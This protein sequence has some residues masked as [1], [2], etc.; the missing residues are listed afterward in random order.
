M[1]LRFSD[2]PQLNY[3]GDRRSTLDEIRERFPP[4]MRGMD[5]APAMGSTPVWVYEATGEP[6]YSIHHRGQWQKLAYE[7]DDRTG[8]TSWRMIGEAVLQP[9]GWAPATRQNLK[10]E[11]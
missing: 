3:G 8:K 11:R 6:F 2:K 4:E 5:S 7:V 9:S 10:I 1:T